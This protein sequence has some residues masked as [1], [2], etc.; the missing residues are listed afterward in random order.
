MS[1]RV[2]GGDVV[3]AFLEAAGLRAAFGVISIHNMPILDAFYRGKTIRFV[4]ARGEAGAVNMA[5]SYARVIATLPQPPIVIGH[6]F[7]GL[8]TLY[9]MFT[10]PS[11]FWG[12]LAGSPDILFAN[13]FLVRQEEEFAKAHKDLPVRI[14]FA[15]G[16]GES[17]VTSRIAFVRTFAGRNYNGLHWDAR[18]IEGEGHASAKPEF[19]SLGLRFLFG[20]G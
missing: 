11:L 1:E 20:N 4:P 19:Y 3:A 2:T 12:Y 6:S 13:N 18:V 9:A 8:F 7:G 17:F 5:D 10:D 16:G 14:F 15:T